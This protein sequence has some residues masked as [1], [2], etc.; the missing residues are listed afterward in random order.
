M[1]ISPTLALRFAAILA[2]LQCMTV[3]AQA[4]VSADQTVLSIELMLPRNSNDFVKAQQW[5]RVFE[6]F[7]QSVR[8]SKPLRSDEPEIDETIRGTLRIVKLRGEIDREGILRFPKKSFSFDQS[9]QLKE[10]LDEL[11][12]YGAQ[13][14][15]DGK[16][17]WG[18]NSEQFESVV[19]GLSKA[20][21]TESSGLSVAE[22]LKSLPISEELPTNVVSTAQE[23]FNK[24]QTEIVGQEIKGVAAGCA[25][26]YVL[27]QQGLGFKPLRTPAG[28]VELS[29][30]SLD[31]LSDAWPVGWKIDDVTPRNQIAPALFKAVNTGFDAAP[32]QTV[33]EAIATQTQT[34]ILID[35][36]ACV[37]RKVDPET[38]KVSYPQKQTAWMIVLNSVV[39]QINLTSSIRQDEAGNAIVWVAPFVPYSIKDRP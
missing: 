39:R 11:K 27:Q 34:P 13:G 17:L 2:C 5:G 26:A 4:Q 22:I 1:V 31:S 30:D 7:G 6:K 16:Q 19:D 29:I 18:L 10:W 23:Q 9:E 12:V 3:P 38:A 25:L 20:V 33:L 15:P 14:T 8:I 32:L 21:E 28:T 24:V 37:Q 35:R 36:R